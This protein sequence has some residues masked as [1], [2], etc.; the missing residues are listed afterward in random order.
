MLSIEVNLPDL[1]YGTSYLGLHRGDMPE[2]PV[3]NMFAEQYDT[4]QSP[5]LQSREGLKTISALD[6]GPIRAIYSED[7]VLGG[8]LFVL[9]GSTVYADDVAI[10]TITGS[11]PAFISGFENRVFICAGTDIYEYDGTTFK[12]CT[13]PDTFSVSA[14]SIGTDR[15]IYIDKGTGHF[16]WSDVLSDTLETLSFATAEQAPD[17]L[18][19]LMFIG[20]TLVLFGSSSVEFWPASSSNPNLPWTPLIG[21]TYQ[22]GI[23]GTGCATRFQNT[24]AWIT[25]HNQVCV[26][27]ADK[28]VSNTTLDERLAGSTSASLWHFFYKGIQFLAVRLDTETWVFSDGSGQWS[29]FESYGEGNWIPQCY[30]S[31]VFGSAVD[32]RLIEWSGTYDDFGDILER[33]F[34]AGQA[35]T[36]DTV[37]AFNITLRANAGHTSYLTGTYANPTIS[38]RTSKDGGY[39]W[40]EWRSISLGVNGKYRQMIRWTSLG[41]FGY[42]AILVEFR[43]TDPV[44]FRVSGCTINEG[45]A[46]S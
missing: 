44:P 16:Y 18:L 9:S 24:F 17:N 21:R 1:K 19:D 23:R 10:G 26:G 28:V 41:Y 5:V 7:G 43:V 22:E 32:G 37:P 13:L 30:N 35:I 11:G 6:T 27:S 3:I 40:A 15:L 4:E 42:P 31:N 20:D 34:R 12:T 46:D 39:E 45:L 38:L 2:L 36:N 33:R 29:V 8:A 14:I 25:N